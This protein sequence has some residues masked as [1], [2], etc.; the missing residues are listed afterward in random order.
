[1]LLHRARKKLVKRVLKTLLILVLSFSAVSMI[2]TVIFFHTAFP[3]SDEPSAFSF[4]YDTIDDEAYPS[5]QIRFS[6]GDHTLTGYCYS[7]PSPQALVVIAAGFRESGAAYLSQMMLFYDHGYDVFCYDATGVGE[8][9]GNSTVGLSQPTLD[10]QAALSYIAGDPELSA[11]PI[12]LYGHSTGGYAA[13]VCVGE[14]QVKAAVILS[15]FE[16]PTQ[17]MRETARRYVGVLADIEYPFLSLEN[18]LVFGEQGNRSASES[19]I[20]ASIPIAVYEGADDETIPASVRLSSK[21]KEPSGSMT[22][23]VCDEENHSGHSD[24]WLSDRA[25]EERKSASPDPFLA[26]EM[27]PVFA[28]SLLLFYQNALQPS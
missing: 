8:S 18:T 22:L 16:S 9:E 20:N 19:L 3:R 2:V 26:N 1:M 14:P 6:S 4:S 24:L 23:T 7:N 13:A 10:L 15:G 21:I 17:L 28:E 5:R 12:L 27:D 11:L 25:V